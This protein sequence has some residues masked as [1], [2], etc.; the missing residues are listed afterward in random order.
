MT[1]LEMIL[2]LAQLFVA[3]AVGSLLKYFNKNYPLKKLINFWGETITGG[4]CGVAAGGIAHEYWTLSQ[5]MLF[6]IALA[7]GVFGLKI[8]DIALKIFK[9][10][11][12]AD[13]DASTI[14]E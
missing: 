14:D 6:V 12:N 1:T 4:F 13:D 3:G 11:I 9:K 5:L 10:K 8:F 2:L 7:G